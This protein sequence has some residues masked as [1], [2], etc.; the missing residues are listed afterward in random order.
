MAAR[1]N[2]LANLSESLLIPFPTLLI[3]TGWRLSVVWADWWSLPIIGAIV[4]WSLA[5]SY[6]YLREHWVKHV[7]R[8]FLAAK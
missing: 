4:A 7:Y 6:L 5:W 1:N 3:V 8:Q 2:N